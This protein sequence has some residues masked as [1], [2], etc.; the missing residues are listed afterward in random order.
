MNIN[1]NSEVELA[2]IRLVRKAKSLDSFRLVALIALACLQG[3]TPTKLANEKAV[4]PSPSTSAQP[5]CDPF[6]VFIKTPEGGNLVTGVT[7]SRDGDGYL[8]TK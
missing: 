3:C 5:K 6:E 8:Y 7:V 2:P 4:N 1:R